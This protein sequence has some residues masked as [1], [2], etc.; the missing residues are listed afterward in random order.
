VDLDFECLGIV[1]PADKKLPNY[2]AVEGAIG[3]GK[4]TLARNLATT[5]E[6]ETLLEM[7]QENPFLERFYADPKANALPAQ[8]YFLFQR[9]RQLKEIKQRDMFHPVRVADFLLEKDPIFAEVTLDDDELELYQM[10]YEQLTLEA[11]KPDLVIYLQAPTEVLQQR[12]RKRG[13]NSEKYIEPSYLARLNAAYA[14]YFHH[15]QAS[16]LLIVNATEVNLANNQ[17]HYADLVSYMLTIK[18]GTH[19]YN[20]LAN[21]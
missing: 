10:V 7:P 11:P 4:T 20:P 2:I 9:T 14:S 17:Q 12:I 13:L 15:Y 18:T 8:L 6:Y 21:K 5:F 1:K 16:P 3:V 19:Y